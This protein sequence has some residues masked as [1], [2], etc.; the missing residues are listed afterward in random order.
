[1]RYPALS[2]RPNR[3]FCQVVSRHDCLVTP[4]S[5]KLST[6]PWCSVSGRHERVNAGTTAHH[7]DG[8]IPSTLGLANQSQVP[9]PRSADERLAKRHI[10]NLFGTDVVTRDVLLPAGFKNKL[11]DPHGSHISLQLL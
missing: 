6:L 9:L 7:K 4:V 5:F 3:R 11:V 1:V 2:R 8:Q 10:F